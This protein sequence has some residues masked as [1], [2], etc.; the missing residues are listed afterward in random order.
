MT[1]LVVPPP[2]PLLHLIDSLSYWEDATPS[3]ALNAKS[4][5]C[6]FSIQIDL[7]DNELRWYADSAG[8]DCHRLK[9]VT[10]SGPQTRPFAIDVWQP[11]FMRVVF[12]PTGA[13]AFFHLP[14]VEL[15]DAHFSLEDIWGLN[16][17]RLHQQ[18]VAA[19]TP[20]DAL[21]LLGNGLSAAASLTVENHPAVAN[22]LSRARTADPVAITELAKQA[23]LS[24]KRFIRLFSDAVGLTPKLYLRI[25]RFE[26]LLARIEAES[27][28]DWV[29]VA[30]DHGYFDQPHLI[31]DFQ[32]FTGMSPAKYLAQRSPLYSAEQ[33]TQQHLTQ[34][35]LTQ[36]ELTQQ[37]FTKR[38][39]AA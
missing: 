38:R 8:N 35:D 22:A 29:Q 15:R 17:E 9:G 5:S 16:A 12:K 23:G 2:K 18:L 26:R 32:E 21:R 1:Y 31:R 28:P 3:Q 24:A 39:T 11:Q 33:L 20:T 19:K 36:Q 6:A 25:A 34:R 13:R 10:V 4:A 27:Q 7:H 37:D 14:L 30:V